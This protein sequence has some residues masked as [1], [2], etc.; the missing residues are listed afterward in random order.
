M[1]RIVGE[2]LSAAWGL[3]R[4]EI[5][6][7]DADMAREF[8]KDLGVGLRYQKRVSQQQFVVDAQVDEVGKSDRERLP[9][10]AEGFCVI[11]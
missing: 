9:C 11:S 1:A 10:E 5:V 4:Q 6:G 8:A 7:L 3:Y 2:K